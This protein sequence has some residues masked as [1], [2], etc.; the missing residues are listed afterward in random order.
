MTIIDL[1]LPIIVSAVVMFI[2]GAVI[3]M[4]MPWHKN[5]WRRTPD[6]EAVRASLKGA[7]PGTY[8]VP[9][10][11]DRAAFDDPAM[12]QKFVQGPQAY[13]TVVPSGLPKMGGKLAMMFVCNLFVAVLCAYLL[14]RTVGA[15]ADYLTVFRI[16]GTV[17]FI[18]YST[19][20]LQESIWF[21]RP[22]SLTATAY[23]DALIY[24]LLTG[25]VFGWL[26]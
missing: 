17:A 1:W 13:I 23:L 11:P 9:N 16:T 25:G 14:S 6:E 26:A 4:A 12:Q 24:A 15:G 20:Y 21:G 2:A 8:T 7:V 3:W 10:C 22:W 19:A 5:E 18:A